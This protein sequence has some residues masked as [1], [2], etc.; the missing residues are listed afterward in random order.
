M[1]VEAYEIIK[2]YKFLSD[3]RKL[4][5]PPLSAVKPTMD[6]ASL[7]NL[8]SLQN[9]TSPDM[10]VRKNAALAILNSISN[11]NQQKNLQ[12]ISPD[13]INAFCNLLTCADPQLIAAGLQVLDLLLQL[14]SD[15]AELKHSRNACA[16]FIEACGGLDKIEMLRHH[17]NED[18]YEKAMR[19]LE[20]YFADEVEEQM[21]WEAHFA[22][23]FSLSD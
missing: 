21:P 12:F 7:Q 20:T 17:E 19:I 15:D 9:L 4:M 6:N 22:A 13:Y 3:I 8:P 5:T 1:P 10:N 11:G 14:G 2:D 23:G 18:L 16:R